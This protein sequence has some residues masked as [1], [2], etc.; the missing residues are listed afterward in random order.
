MLKNTNGKI[1]QNALPL[2]QLSTK[3]GEAIVVLQDVDGM[4]GKYV[5][6]NKIYQKITGY[7]VEELLSHTAFD[8]ISPEYTEAARLRYRNILAGKSPRNIFKLS[9]LSKSGHKVP[10]D[11]TLIPF[12]YLGESSVLGRIRDI[13]DPEKGRDALLKERNRYA[14]LFNNAPVAINEIDYSDCKRYARRFYKRGQCIEDYF[15]N[16]MEDFVR[17][18]SRQK[19]I[20]SNRATLDLWEA[21][22]IEE[23]TSYNVGR[24]SLGV[25]QPDYPFVR[26]SIKCFSDMLNGV[27]PA[28]CISTVTTMTGKIKH[29]LSYI[30]VDPVSAPS[31]SHVLYA[32]V[33]I[34]ERVKA[35][36]ALNDYKCQLESIVKER[37]KALSISQEELKREIKQCKI[38]ENKLRVHQDALKQQM[39]QRYN[40]HV[41]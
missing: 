15:I 35:E 20:C 34:T 24:Y 11:I 30:Y 18:I 10:I 9:L 32:I 26:S 2:L 14:F 23:L 28:P 19:I 25:Y 27:D 21:G 3:I 12:K 29:I 22:S 38:A 17:C 8:L 31:L 7:S 4:E 16:H 39:K 37:T 5:F 13:R 36:D 41:R 6:V 33:D 1:Q 40:S